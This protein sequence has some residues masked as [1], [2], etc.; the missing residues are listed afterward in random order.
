MK[1]ILLYKIKTLF[2]NKILFKICYCRD[3]YGRGNDIP[4]LNLKLHAKLIQM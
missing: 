3:T 2:N 1:L 4:V